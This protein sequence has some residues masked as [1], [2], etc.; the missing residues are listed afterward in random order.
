MKW[1]KVREEGRRGLESLRTVIG[2]ITRKG[3]EHQGDFIAG[4]LLSVIR[5]TS[6]ALDTQGK[7][8]MLCPLFYH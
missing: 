8:A 1:G 7:V 4:H 5:K 6:A 3:E 2:L